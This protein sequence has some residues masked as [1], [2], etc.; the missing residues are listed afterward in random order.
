MNNIEK[1]VKGLSECITGKHCN[2]EYCPYSNVDS[3]QAVLKNDALELIKTQQETISALREQ[4]SDL[5][6]E[7]LMEYDK[8]WE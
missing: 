2:S 8:Y 7:L 6:E 1:V 4:V 5:N 3:C